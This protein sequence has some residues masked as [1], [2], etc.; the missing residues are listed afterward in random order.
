MS[1]NFDISLFLVTLIEVVPLTLIALELSS[2]VRNFLEPY[3]KCLGRRLHIVLDAIYSFIILYYGLF[4]MIPLGKAMLELHPLLSPL[5][6]VALIF[7]TQVF[8]PPHPTPFQI[9]LKN[10]KRR[11]MQGRR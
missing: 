9:F 2:C 6:V 5:P 7:L 11:I 4:I 8:P 3:V 10:L 1:I